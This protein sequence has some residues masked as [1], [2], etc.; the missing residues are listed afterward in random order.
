MLRSAKRA[1][2]RLFMLRAPRQPEVGV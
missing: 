2:L 1:A